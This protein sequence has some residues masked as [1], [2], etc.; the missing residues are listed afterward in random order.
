M[1]QYDVLMDIRI[2]D[3]MHV[4]LGCCWPM[5][6]KWTAGRRWMDEQTDG[7]D[8]VDTAQNSIGQDGVLELHH[9]TEGIG[10]RTAR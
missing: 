8:V 7:Y 10:R 1:M 6:V 5:T 3:Q 9:R 4:R 2:H